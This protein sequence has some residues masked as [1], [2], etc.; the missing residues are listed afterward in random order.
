MI[1]Y[2]KTTRGF[3]DSDFSG[4]GIPDD[5]VE[6]PPALR[7]ELL[8]AQST[9]AVIGFDDSTQLPVVTTP[10]LLTVDGMRDVVFTEARA[11]REVVLN[12][13]TGIGVRAMVAGDSA[14]A[15]TASDLQQKLL[16]IT[17]HP[18]VLAVTAEQGADVL[19]QT[20]LGI[21]RSYALAVPA[22]I[23]AAF[24]EVDQ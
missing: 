1:Y 12:R 15:A 17:K 7:W 20:I 22:N 16:D 14:T 24:N 8:S 13:L 11:F 21:Y 3:Y 4:D 5:A 6:I 23:R 10:P 9:G 19:R 2:S 18:A